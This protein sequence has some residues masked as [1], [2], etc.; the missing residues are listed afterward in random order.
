[1][2]DG[3]LQIPEAIQS[4]LFQQLA[5]PAVYA[6]GLMRFADDAY[7]GTGWF[8]L[9]AIQVAVV[10]LVLRPLESWRPVEVWRDRR[11]V[12]ADVV[13]T[14]L[15]R[16]GALPLLFFIVLRPLAEAVDG[17]LRFAGYIPPN[18]EDLAPGL[19]RHPLG[20][21]LIYLAALDFFQYLSHRLQHRFA[22]WWAL[23]SVH[24]S[25]RQLTFWADDRNHVVDGLIAEAWRAA[26]A[27]AIGVP[28]GQFVGI[29]LLT[30]AIESLAHAN[31]RL[32][33]GTVGDHVLVS[34]RY[35][36]IHHGIGVG[37]EGP[38]GGCNFATLFP[39]W[40]VLLRTHN[41]RRIAPPT[42]ITDQLQGADYGR[43]FL[44]QQCKGLQR[45]AA[46]LLPRRGASKTDRLVPS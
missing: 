20:S 22:W 1:M 15:D 16:L 44:S 31:V 36:R 34:P 6:L 12:R 9:G 19:M 35:H 28:P 42:G 40:D 17:A 7:T 23:H 21:F 10:W 45:L 14:L 38:A 4:W 30:R 41:F 46:V 26:G 39:V 24:H 32:G 8:V 11:A 33:F 2:L 27:L 37:H 25:Q 5:L 3:L 43:G 18:L 29:V 13:Y